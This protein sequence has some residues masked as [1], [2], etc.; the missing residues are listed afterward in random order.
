[1]VANAMPSGPG[2][3][4]QVKVPIRRASRV[5][6]PPDHECCV[7]CTSWIKA[8]AAAHSPG[9]APMAEVVLVADASSGIRRQAGEAG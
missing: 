3:N 9:I 4:L 6:Q 2:A 7:L 5:S 1:M 8:A